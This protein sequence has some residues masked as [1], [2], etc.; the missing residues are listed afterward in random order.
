[1]C[2]L[3]P[4]FSWFGMLSNRWVA[5][6]LDWVVISMVFATAV[7]CVLAGRSLPASMAGLSLTYALQ[8][9]QA[10]RCRC[11]LG[12]FVAL[13]LFPQMGATFQFAVR[14][15]SEAEATLT[16][17]E[18]IC[19]AIPQD[20]VYWHA[21]SQEDGAPAD[22]VDV[23]SDWPAHGTILFDR[24]SLRYR[25]HLRLALDQVS[26]S[27]RSA[28]KIGDDVDLI[29]CFLMECSSDVCALAGV[30]GRTGSGKSTL[31]LALFRILELHSG[32][33][34]VDGVDIGSVPVETLRG[35]MSIIPQDP[36]LFC[37][38]VRKNLDPFLQHSDEE[39][40]R[41]LDQVCEEGVV[42]VIYT[43]GV[44][45]SSHVAQVSLK[46]FVESD[47]EKLW[48][49]VTESGSNFS[50]GQRQ[51]LCLAR[52]LLKRAKIIVMDEATAAVDVETDALVQTTVRSCFRDSAL[53]II[54]H[55]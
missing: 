22:I 6:R 53:V 16:S 27:V 33:I 8:V 4:P 34:H 28:E 48:K 19:T 9:G 25:P 31:G 52:A 43:L 10:C 30:V 12:R 49:P 29:A 24:V 51:L 3:Y 17:V 46:G 1:V 5:V 26:F 20:P 45:S 47:P 42:L 23:P 11:L 18:R 21:S 50:A 36:V 54:A 35:R 32:S 38:T 14:Q 37:G 40:W 2:L 44:W 13:G 55:R 15:M 41:V 39:L 7:L